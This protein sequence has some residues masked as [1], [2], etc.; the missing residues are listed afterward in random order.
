MIR[1]IAP[2]ALILALLSAGPSAADR[3]GRPA[4]AAVPVALVQ[5]PGID[6]F[7]MAIRKCWNVGA[8]SEKALATRI[9]LSAEFDAQGRPHVDA[10]ALIAFDQGDRDAAAEVFESARRAL[11]RCGMAGLPLPAALRGTD[12]I[13]HLTF[14][15]TLAE[16]R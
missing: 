5:G 16:L 9:T 2:L 15:P 4:P 10:I 8:L 14:D 11:I 1:R 7:S 13:A 12:R 6:A 3:S